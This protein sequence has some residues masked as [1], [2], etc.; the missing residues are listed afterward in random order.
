VEIPPLLRDFQAE[1]ESPAFGL[2]HGAAF[3][4]ALFYPQ[5]LLQSPKREVSRLYEDIT[6]P[7][8]V[9]LFNASVSALKVWRAVDVL[10]RVD[11]FLR[12]AAGSKDG[13][14]R[15][16]AIHGNRLILH[17]VFKKLGSDIFV[18]DN[19]DAEM[20]KVPTMAEEC[21]EAVTAQILLNYSS[22]YPGQ[23]FKNIT[24]CKQIAAAIG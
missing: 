10:R 22:S 24:K 3:S 17:L 9:V 18:I 13:K 11:V 20:A 6:K 23:L 5:I 19:A 7:P 1:G 2:F 15:L 16:V 4:T 21:L 14:D 12:N 8:Y